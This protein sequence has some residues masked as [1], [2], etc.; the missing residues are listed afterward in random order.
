M[1]VPVPPVLTIDDIADRWSKE[2]GC[3]F[4]DVVSVIVRA[5]NKNEKINSGRGLSLY[6]HAT[7]SIDQDGEVDINYSGLET[8]DDPL[9][10]VLD[11]IFSHPLNLSEEEIRKALRLQCFYRDTFLKLIQEYG[12]CNLPEFWVASEKDEVPTDKTATKMDAMRV[13][14]E[15]IIAHG[16]PANI[17]SVWRKMIERCEAKC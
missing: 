2:A 14:I 11:Y 16:A 4:K 12:D 13:E 8:L 1:T 3:N 5:M 7:A 9:Y 10:D 17:E 15:D 6:A